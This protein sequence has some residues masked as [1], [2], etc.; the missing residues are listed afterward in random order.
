M[1]VLAWTLAAVCLLAAVA[2]FV[3]GQGMYD[4]LKQIARTLNVKVT[5]PYQ[6]ERAAQDLV[7]AARNLRIEV[8]ALH[9]RLAEKARDLDGNREE[10]RRLVRRVNELL[11]ERTE[12]QKKLDGLDADRSVVPGLQYQV[13]GLKEQLASANSE[14]EHLQE[15]RDCRTAERDQ[16]RKQNVRLL[17]ELKAVRDTFKEDANNLDEVLDEFEGEPV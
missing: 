11:D 13:H 14:V 7:E 6:P 2:G 15:Q 9:N 12:L 3:A 1:L 4:S 10:N 8:A 17:D 16:L 5:D